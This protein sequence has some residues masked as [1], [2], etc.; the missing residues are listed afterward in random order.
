M[1]MPLSHSGWHFVTL[2]VQFGVTFD[3]F[4]YM[5]MTLGQFESR[6]ESF[7]SYFGYMRARFL[8][9]LISP[10]DFNDFIKKLF[11]FQQVLKGHS[12]LNLHHVI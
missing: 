10:T 5:K 9:T 3:Y 11:V 12:T 7:S 8:K 2:G 6:L 4:G 1:R